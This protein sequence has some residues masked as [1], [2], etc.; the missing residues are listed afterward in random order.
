MHPRTT[1][2]VRLEG[3]LALG[4]GSISLLRVVVRASHPRLLRVSA[5]PP[6]V[7]SCVLAC[8]RGLQWILDRSRITTCGRLFE[9]TDENSPGQTWCDAPRRRLRARPKTP[10]PVPVKSVSDNVAERLALGEKTVSFWQCRFAPKR[11]LTTKRGR[12]AR[13]EPTSLQT[14]V[15]SSD[16]PGILADGQLRTLAHLSSSTDCG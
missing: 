14:I 16:P 6:L 1:A 5:R 9:G 10:L 3:P 12:P 7:S 11:P 13:R 2:V 15:M 8:R 4:H